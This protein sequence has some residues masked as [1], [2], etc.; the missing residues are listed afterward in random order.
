MSVET[1]IRRKSARIVAPVTLSQEATMRLLTAIGV[2]VLAIGMSESA[3]QRGYSTAI[4]QVADNH[5]RL[6]G[7]VQIDGGAWKL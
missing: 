4:E 1:T 6:T 2:A 3:A 5:V 7:E